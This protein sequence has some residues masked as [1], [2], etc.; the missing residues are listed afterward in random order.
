MQR[1]LQTRQFVIQDA[2]TV[3]KAV[4]LFE[5]SQADFG[6]CL[7]DRFGAVYNCEYTAT[8]EKGAAKAGIRLVE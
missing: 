6:A 5:T 1:I 3:C 7:I 8:F 4:R 2:E